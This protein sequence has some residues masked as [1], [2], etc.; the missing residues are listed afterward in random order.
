MDRLQFYLTH[1]SPCAYLSDRDSANI[2][3]DPAVPL[4]AALYDQLIQHGFRRSGG[5]V[6][7]PHCPHCSACVPLRIPVHDFAPRRTDRRLLRNNQDIQIRPLPPIFQDEHFELYRR[8]LAHRHPGGGM[9]SAEPEDYLGFLTAEWSRTRFAE[10]RRNDQ[11]LAIAVFDIVRDGLS[12]V[13]TFFDPKQEPLALGRHA[14]LWEIEEARRMGLNYLY[15]G[16]WI[17]ESPKMAYKIHYQP[18]EGLIN[19]HW[20]GITPPGKD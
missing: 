12:A 2:V 18:A 17:A 7:R 10:F 1:E 3:P 8:Y 4:T 14:V 6:Y 5:H 19:E 13:Y 15:L 9:E 20:V 16:Y 11:L